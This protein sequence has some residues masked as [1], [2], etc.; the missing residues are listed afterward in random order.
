MVLLRLLL[1]IIFP[2]AFT[3]IPTLLWIRWNDCASLLLL[4]TVPLHNRCYSSER[5][6]LQRKQLMEQGSWSLLDRYRVGN[7]SCRATKGLEPPS[8]SMAE[9]LRLG[10]TRRAGTKSDIPTEYG[11]FYRICFLAR[12]LPQLLHHVFLCCDPFRGEQ[13]HLQGG[14]S[15]PQV[16]SC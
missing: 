8:S 13:R 11:D 12:V 2:Y 7:I 14:Y 4:R 10:K 1:L 3:N 16:H 5:S 6:R 9:V 15:I